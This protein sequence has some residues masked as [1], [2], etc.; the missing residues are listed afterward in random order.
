MLHDL[1]EL[2]Q[3]VA[4]KIYPAY[5]DETYLQSTQEDT[6]PDPKETKK[7]VDLLVEVFGK[8]NLPTYEEYCEINQKD[9]QVIEEVFG[10]DLVARCKPEWEEQEKQRL[11]LYQGQENN[12]E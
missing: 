5:A 8:P 7:S 3:G 2:E 1:D 12:H 10:G 9:W 4:N 6:L 11:F